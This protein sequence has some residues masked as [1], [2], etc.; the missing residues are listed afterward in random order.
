MPC[1]PFADLGIPLGIWATPEPRYDGDM[2]LNSFVTASMFVSTLRRYYRDPKAF[3]WFY[4]H[5]EDDAFRRRF[6]VTVGA[7]KGRRALATSRVAW[8]GGLAPGFEN[9]RFDQRDLHARLGGAQGRARGSSGPWSTSRERSAT[10]EAKQVA[11][12]MVAAAR[13]VNVPGEFVERNARLYLALRE[14]CDRD[15]AN[16][17]ALAGLAGDPG[18]LRHLAVAGAVLAGRARRHPEC[19]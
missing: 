12:E 18:R 16:A 4:G 6:G 19:P 10:A 11:A 2:Q 8:I 7:L 17:V 1:L 9:L 3:K 5:V 15:G 14:V 13:A